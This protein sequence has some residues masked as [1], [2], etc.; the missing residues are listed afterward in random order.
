MALAMGDSAIT[1]RRTGF[2]EGNIPDRGVHVSLC[3][4]DTPLALPGLASSWRLYYQ[5][6]PV[7]M[8][9]EFSL[10]SPQSRTLGSVS[11]ICRLWPNECLG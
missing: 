7:T 9:L 2:H 3:I 6:D 5:A 10:Q 4:G 11:L 1:R 8:H